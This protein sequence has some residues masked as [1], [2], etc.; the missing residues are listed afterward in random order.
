[1]QTY[2]RT[3]LSLFPA[4]HLRVSFLRICSSRL[5]IDHPRMQ[6]Q[7]DEGEDQ[8]SGGK[9]KTGEMRLD[10]SSVWDVILRQENPLLLFSI[11]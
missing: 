1:M 10:V 3:F 2:D 9:K 6:Q 8:P 7:Q 11:P 5:E 4:R